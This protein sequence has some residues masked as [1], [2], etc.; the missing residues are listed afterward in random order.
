MNER[1]ERDRIFKRYTT[2]CAACGI[3][4]THFTGYVFHA[5]TKG[6]RMLDFCNID[7]CEAYEKDHDKHVDRRGAGEHTKRK[8]REQNG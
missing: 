3:P 8:R 6:G 2:Q 5:Q 4:S 7:C 1:V